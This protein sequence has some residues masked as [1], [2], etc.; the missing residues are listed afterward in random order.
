MGSCCGKEHGYSGRVA[1]EPSAWQLAT[2]DDFYDS[3]VSEAHDEHDLVEL[4]RSSLQLQRQDTYQNGE[5]SPVPDGQI[6]SLDFNLAPRRSS[7]KP[8]PNLRQ[9]SGSI[10]TSKDT[11][12]ALVLPDIR[13]LNDLRGSGS[14]TISS[15]TPS[16]S[17]TSSPAVSRAPSKATIDV[18]NTTSNLDKTVIVR[19]SESV[20]SYTYGDTSDLKTQDSAALGGVL[21]GEDDEESSTLPFV[22][23]PALSA[24]AHILTPG[25]INT[26]PHIPSTKA[27]TNAISKSQMPKNDKTYVKLSLDYEGSSSGA[28]EDALDS[29][30]QSSRA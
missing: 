12:E 10:A 18:S 7:H 24:H 23:P 28:Y 14:F 30:T 9:S 21:S 27:S 8:N 1:E 25:K 29:M 15:R 22:L 4:Q 16:V 6:V 11:T 26:P 17:A 3:E 5:D 19:N 13:A 2:M 20:Y